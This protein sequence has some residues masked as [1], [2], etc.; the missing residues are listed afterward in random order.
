MSTMNENMKWTKLT[1]LLL[2]FPLNLSAPFCTSTFTFKISITFLD[3]HTQ[4]KSYSSLVYTMYAS[5][6]NNLP[7]C[8]HVSSYVVRRVLLSGTCP[9]SSSMKKGHVSKV[10][11]LNKHVTKDRGNKCR[12][13]GTT[14]AKGGMLAKLGRG[15]AHRA[16]VAIWH[17][18]IWKSRTVSFKRK[19]ITLFFPLNH[20][21]GHDGRSWK[22]MSMCLCMNI[23]ACGRYARAWAYGCTGVYSWIHPW[24]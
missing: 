3:V 23:Y 14:S 2:F 11:S 21:M 10:L 8:T 7:S 6:W 5:T 15:N 17:C 20:S 12:K 13:V 19:N 18:A 4:E 24:Y 9:T 16:K 22:L 1:N